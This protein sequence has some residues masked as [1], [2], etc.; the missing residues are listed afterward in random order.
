MS[1]LYQRMLEGEAKLAVVGMG[2]VGMPLAI[3][4]ARHFGVIGFDLNADKIAKYRA[5]IDLTME[6][7]DDAIRASSVEFTSDEKRLTDAHFFIVAVP[8]PVFEDKRPDLRPVE[9]ACVMVGRHMQPGSVVVFESTV[10]PGVTE[11]VCVPILERESGLRCGPDFKVGY[12]PERINPGDK[13]HRLDNICKIVSGMDDDALQ[14]ISDVYATIIDAGV[15][16]VSNIRTAEAI[17][18]VENSQRD[19][20]IAFVNEMAMLFDLID[21]DTNEVIDGMNTKWNALGFRPGLVGG[22]CI[23]VDPYYLVYEAEKHRFTDQIIVAARR[24]NNVMGKYVARA[25]VKQMTRVGLAPLKARVVIMG[26][27]FKENCPDT[28]NTRAL[29]IFNELK[30]YN[31]SPVICDPLAD[32]NEVRRDYGVELTPLEDVHA[33]DCLIIAV[34]HDAYRDMPFDSLLALFEGNA[35]NDRV[36][37][38]V[39]GIIDKRMAEEYDH[40]ALWRL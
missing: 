40:V 6:V 30:E 38:D 7:G 20:N 34:G 37:I 19:I 13:V 2:Y 9:S 27:T 3:A 1:T 5:G 31:I 26:L 10:Y 15:Y 17:K 12:S 35:G 16:P 36:I 22:H 8:T 25:A 11:G 24:I 14:T 4:M 18:L 33:V 32:P 21:I 29:D 39:K 23:G 28:R